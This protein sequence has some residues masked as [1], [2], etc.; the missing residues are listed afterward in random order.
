MKEIL[1]YWLRKGV[2]GF[3][4]DAVPYLF[5]VEKNSDGL[6]DDEP[7]SGDCQNDPEVGKYK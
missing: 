7:L 5:E 1:R 3:R 2:S 4:C 6:Y